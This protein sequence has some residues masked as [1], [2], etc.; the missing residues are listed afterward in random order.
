MANSKKNSARNNTGKKTGAS[1]KTGGKS[2]RQHH[3]RLALLAGCFLLVT[4]AAGLYVVL[5]WPLPQQHQPAPPHLQQPPATPPLTA[6]DTQPATVPAATPPLPATASKRIAIIMDDIGLDLTTDSAA[7]QLEPPITVSIF[8]DERYSTKLMLLAHDLGREIIIHIPMEP[9]NY[10]RNN[11]GHLGLFWQRS[12]AEITARIRTIIA[13]LPYAVGGNNHMGS[14]FT[15][16]VHQMDL[17]LMELKKA[18]LFFVDS[19]TFAESVAAQEAK[20]LG[21]PTAVRD[22]FLDNERDSDKI[23]AQLHKLAH[24]AR[25]RGSAIGICHPYPQTITALRE[26]LPQLEQLGVEIVPVQ[27]LLY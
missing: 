13:S 7:I 1:K 27:Q 16:H 26:F 15:R 6:P 21:V 2:A 4:I 23:L 14:E 19:R 24:L 9:I 18:G 10:P 25:Q 17:V 8:P 11:P 22:M 5:H 12:D 3:T 20:R